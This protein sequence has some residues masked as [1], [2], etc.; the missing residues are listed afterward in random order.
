MK[1]KATPS[2][3]TTQAIGQKFAGRTLLPAIAAFAVTGWVQFAQA[4]SEAHGEAHSSGGMPQLDPS[5][6][7][8]QLIWLGIT[9]VALYIIMSRFALPK[10]GEVLEERQRKIDRDIDRANSLKEEADQVRQA[11]EKEVADARGQAQGLLRETGDNLAAQTR[12]REQA[13]AAEDARRIEEAEAAIATKRQEALSHVRGISVDVVKAA[14]SRVAGLDV[15]DDAAGAAV[16]AVM[17]AQG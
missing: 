8:P 10:V 1:N 7:S 4:A 11:Y 14:A 17:N 16:D 6:F 2:G 5:S 13:Q 12:E 15:N 9:F 3:A